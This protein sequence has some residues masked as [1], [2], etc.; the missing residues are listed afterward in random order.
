MRVPLN[1]LSMACDSGWRFLDATHTQT[2]EEVVRDGDWGLTTLARPSIL[3]ESGTGKRLVSTEDGRYLVNNGLHAIKA[4]QNVAAV[5]ATAPDGAE[6]PKWLNSEL[7]HIFFSGVLVDVVEYSSPDCIDRCVIQAMAHEQER[8]RYRPPTLKHKV[9]L[10][11]KIFDGLRD[12]SLVSIK[13]LDVLG[14]GKFSAIEGWIVLAR[15]LDADVLAV[16]QAKR[17]SLPQEYVI[18]NRFLIGRGRTSERFYRL[19]ARYASVA[20]DWLLDVQPGDDVLISPLTFAN[21]MCLPAKRLELWEESMLKR[22]GGRAQN[23]RPFKRLVQSLK[24]HGRTR[25]LGECLGQCRRVEAVLKEL[26]KMREMGVRAPGDEDGTAPAESQGS[27]GTASAED[28]TESGTGSDAVLKEDPFAQHPHAQALPSSFFGS[29]LRHREE[30]ARPASGVLSGP[31]HARAHGD[32]QLWV[33]MQK[34]IITVIASQIEDQTAREPDDAPV[35]TRGLNTM[36]TQLMHKIL[37]ALRR[38]LDDSGLYLGK[39]PD[40]SIALHTKTAR[41]EGDNVCFVT[42]LFYD[43]T[44][45][46]T[47][48][49]THGSN[50]L[51]VDRFLEIHGVG[52]SLH[53]E[54]GSSLYMAITG[55]GRYIRHYMGVRRGGPNAVLRVQTDRGCGE[56]FV[57]CVV[58][59]DGGVG[60][61]AKSPIVVNYGNEYINMSSTAKASDGR[62]L[63]FK[64]FRL[65]LDEYFAQRSQCVAA[66][67]A[68]PQ[69][70]AAPKAAPA[71]SPESGANQAPMSAQ[72]KNKVAPN[73]APA[74]AAPDAAA[75]SPQ[76]RPP[77]APAVGAP[78][79]KLAKA[80]ERELGT[81]TSPISASLILTGDRL[82]VRPHASVERSHEV[83]PKTVMAK[84]KDGKVHMQHAGPGHVSSYKNYISLSE[85][86]RCRFTFFANSTG[87]VMKMS[88][89]DF[90]AFTIADVEWQTAIRLAMELTQISLVFFDMKMSDGDEAIPSGIALSLKTQ[91]FVKAGEDFVLQ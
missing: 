48:F 36:P 8:N 44:T 50:R 34:E 53:L 86:D 76:K 63:K 13:L 5:L 27:D 9:D 46:L 83:P 15:D 69:R 11:A 43:S 12:W 24:E 88:D 72:K 28:A 61:P 6:T 84:C 64:R 68:N 85:S 3:Q 23:F 30:L 89:F 82:I 14:L 65:M 1:Q 79:A 35:W 41:H 59:T 58:Q 77:P 80:G 18:N 40:G 73:S 45:S 56:V 91:I 78:A 38:E 55:V 51:L 60:I 74:A 31:E 39:L 71:A 4:L 33:G 49:L 75:P 32:L 26:L 10:V 70:K 21:E 22:F 17:P 52:S 57:S 81:I 2:L 29:S 37:V 16:I 87:L 42:G 67:I 7:S 62:D 66:N 54:E 25:I 19:S 20:I 90:C 47:R